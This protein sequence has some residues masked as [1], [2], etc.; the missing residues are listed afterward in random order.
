MNKPAFLWGEYASGFWYYYLLAQLW[1]TP[2]PTLI[3]FAAALLT[4]DLRAQRSRR[5]WL[6]V[7]APVAAFHAAGTGFRPN[8]GLR[9]VLP[10]FPFL[11]LAAGWAAGKALDGGRKARWALLL[12]GVWYAFGTLRVYPHFL[13][14]FN[15]LA[16]GPAGGLRYLSDS[17]LEW[18]QDVAGMRDSIERTPGSRPRVAVFAPLDLQAQGVIA[19]PI[20]LRDLVWPHQNVTYY[21]GTNHLV[22]EA[23]AGNPALHFEWLDRYEP[24]ERI[25]WSIYAYRFSTDPADRDRKDVIFVPRQRWYAEGRAQLEAVLRQNPQFEEARR[26]L[27]ELLAESGATPRQDGRS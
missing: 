18:G 8:I 27:A 6:F 13:A 2:L 7:L 16:G 22:Q 23:Y 21:V 3:L 5:D 24:V 25:G 26:V 14:Y 12:L 10:V 1:K 19:D 4:L 11:L 9:H 20:G 15:E 17:N